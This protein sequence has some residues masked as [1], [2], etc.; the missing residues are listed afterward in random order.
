MPYVFL[1]IYKYFILSAYWYLCSTWSLIVCAYFA[2]L[3][4]WYFVNILLFVL[5]DPFSFKIQFKKKAQFSFLLGIIL[6][7][8]L[9]TI[10]TID[11]PYILFYVQSNISAIVIVFKTDVTEKSDQLLSYML[12]HNHFRPLKTDIPKFQF[13]APNINTLA[14]HTWRTTC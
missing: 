13:L 10:L 9:T 6:N 7:Y 14:M 11:V 5:L 4:S 8:F 3:A 2:F 12:V 1:D